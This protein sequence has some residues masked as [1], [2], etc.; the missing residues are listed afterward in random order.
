VPSNR[1]P[2][3]AIRLLERVLAEPT[4]SEVIGD[5]SELFARETRARHVRFV[6]RAVGFATYFVAMR[7]AAAMRAAVE[8]LAPPPAR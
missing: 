3:P 7:G 4:R 6:I 5:L 2:A 8:G 1:P